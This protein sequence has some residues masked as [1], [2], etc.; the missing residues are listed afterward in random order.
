VVYVYDAVEARVA[1]IIM[2]LPRGPV[3]GAEVG[4]FTG[5]MFRLLLKHKDLALLMVDSWEGDG[6]AY[7]DKNDWHAH[8]CLFDHANVTNF[9]P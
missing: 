7:T 8:L 9:L 6:A 2:R 4:V 3:Q 5:A 1:E